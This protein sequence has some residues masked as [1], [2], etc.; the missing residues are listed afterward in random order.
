MNDFYVN[1][2]LGPIECI[3]EHNQ[4]N[5][6]SVLIMSHGFRGSRESGGRAKGTAIAA[7]KYCDVIRY[8]FTGVQ[9]LSIQIAELE[10]VVK[11]VRSLRPTAKIFLLGRSMGGAASMLYASKD[12]AI[13]GLILWSA[14]H[15]L[16][17]TLI[18][19]MSE[20]AYAKLK[21]GETLHLDDERGQCDITPDF[22]TDYYSLGLEA[23]YHHWD[24]RA[25][26]LLHCEQ[27]EQVPVAQARLNI[28]LLG[29][30]CEAHIFPQG[31]HSIG[32]YSEETA[33]L[34]T[35]WFTKKL[36]RT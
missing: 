30:C 6:D 32:E 3:V 20:E 31:S 24:G 8:N 7:S 14:P 21:R 27:D 18:N 2:P 4:S 9:K 36:N 16:A 29:S 19:V 15:N 11:E 34:I 26:L 12:K 13:S 5:Y 33:T 1:G 23:A 35:N 22:L 28:E 17:E 25:I 10:A